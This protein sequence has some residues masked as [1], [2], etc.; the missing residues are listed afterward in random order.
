MRMLRASR[1]TVTA[2]VAATVALVLT[3]CTSGTPSGQPKVGEGVYP[4]APGTRALTL[5]VGSLLPQTGNLAFLGP[6]QI[7]GVNL[8]VADINA[9][10]EGMQVKLTQRDSGDSTTNTATV[11]T[12]DLLNAG[13][14]AII[15]PASSGV[16]KVVIDQITGA[17]VVEIS[18][19]ATAAE[20]TTWKDK[21]HFFRT[22]PSDTLQ[23]EV[24]GNRIAA[25]GARTLAFITLNDPYGTGL[26]SSVTKAFKAG[27]GS[28]LTSQ[29]FNTGDTSFSSQVAAVA[30]Q[31]PDAVVVISFDEAKII[32]PALIAAGVTARQLYFVDGN[33][34]DYSAEFAPGLIEGATGTQ[35]GSD[36]SRA[37]T[38]S[39]RLLE[40]DPNLKDFNYAAESY[41]A[42]VLIALAAYA[43]NSTK[44]SEIAKYLRQVSGGTGKGTK[45]HSYS[46][47]VALLKKGQ[48]IDY[49]GLSGPITFDE[50]G[51]PTEASIGLFRA[52]H[53]NTWKR[54]GE[55]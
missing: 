46:E 32:I 28:V 7:A 25:D 51:D 38:L 12:T 34:S 19:S 54:I 13:V 22:A 11:S 6:P 37:G 26:E 44:P 40:L 30:A 45:V 5:P 29:R 15:G 35:P 52:Q 4:I 18:P 9:A 47:G 43:A 41:D 17:G 53:D 1:L 16:T 27:G 36:V 24:L 39:S 23:G 49:D 31:R 21:D 3:G 33:L 55:G 48:Q 20:L 2:A 8:A 50:H 42:V 14:S 10:G